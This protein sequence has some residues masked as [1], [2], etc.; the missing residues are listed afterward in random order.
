MLGC[1]VANPTY[2]LLR[3]HPGWS[4]LPA[5]LSIRD[6]RQG[7]AENRQLLVSYVVATY[8]DGA[9]NLIEWRIDDNDGGFPHSATVDSSGNALGPFADGSRVQLRTRVNN[10]HG[11][12]TSSVRTIAI[13]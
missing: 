9:T 11:T 2:A 4:N 8:D 7:G 3:I 6:I 12:T 13:G 5:P 1:A 10:S